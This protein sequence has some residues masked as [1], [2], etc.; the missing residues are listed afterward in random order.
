MTARFLLKERFSKQRLTQNIG[1]KIISLVVAIFLW[2]I[3]V[4]ATDPIVPQTYRNVPVKLINTDVITAQGKTIEVVGDTDMVSVIT[5]KASRSIVQDLGSSIDNLVVTA[6]LKSLSKDGMSIPIE[7][8]TTKYSDKIDSI[9]LSDNTVVVNIENRKTIQLPIIATTS[10]DVESG[11]ILGN[12]SPNTNQVRISGPESVIAKI[13][14][15]E[16]D[17]QVTGFTSDISTQ[18]DVVLYDSEGEVIPKDNLTLNVETVRVDAEILA[19]KKVPVY[20]SVSGIPADG[21]A[22]TGEVE[23]N[24][25]MVTIAG[26]HSVIDNVNSIDIPSSD[27]NITGQSDD[28][29]LVLNLT[30]YLPKG[31]RLAEPYSLSNVTFKVYIEEIISEEHE[32]NTD[33][34][35]IV[36]VPTGYEATVVH[37]DKLIPYTIKGLAQDLERINFS[38]V[39]YKVDFDDYSLLNN[40]TEFEEGT[41]QCFV[42]IEMP[43]GVEAVESIAV[44][45]KLTKTGE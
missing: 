36:N 21:Y 29:L 4:N 28:M 44:S 22:T 13:S 23:V 10:G 7:V 12:I 25:E 3:V 18:V 17:V 41:Y 27:L 9:K 35:E 38:D 2:I 11:Y 31:V 45:V 24:P 1:L 20:Y 42:V 5:I 8:S 19:T 30:E 14:T 34:I 16:V 6:D 32:F 26:P 40:V 37:T 43:S 33:D 39:I 15:A